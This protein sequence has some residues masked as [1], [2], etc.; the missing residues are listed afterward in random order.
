M[1]QVDGRTSLNEGKR[2][3]NL[4]GK[5]WEEVEIEAMKKANRAKYDQNLGLRT[6]L[7]ATKDTRMVE[8]S[9]HDRRWGIGHAL[10]S[11]D[12][13]QEQLWGWNQLGDALESIRTELRDAPI[14]PNVNGNV[15]METK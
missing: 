2:I 3:T 5:N 8:C 7:L 4:N 10:T 15:N 12:K 14:N 11:V 9:P 13:Y 6:A 1:R